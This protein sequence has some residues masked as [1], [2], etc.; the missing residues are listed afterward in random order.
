[1]FFM[2]IF[3]KPSSYVSLFHVYGFLCS[4]LWYF[5]WWFIDGL[6]SDISAE[7]SEYG[8]WLMF[9][10]MVFM[11]INGFYVIQNG[12]YGFYICYFKMVF[13]GIS[14]FIFYFSYFQHG[15]R[16]FVL[17]GP[18]FHFIDTHGSWWEWPNGITLGKTD[19]KRQQ[20]WRECPEA[21]PLMYEWKDIWMVW[22]L[23]RK[24]SEYWCYVMEEELLCKQQVAHWRL[25]PMVSD[26]Q[27]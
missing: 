1:M 13:H 8:L 3:C 15:I 7:V 20:P 12:L 5:D 6:W 14:I 19:P 21:S 4:W 25:S 22:Y 18:K 2:E 16:A 27:A 11:V 10:F 26:M 24:V 17:L 9:C 23:L